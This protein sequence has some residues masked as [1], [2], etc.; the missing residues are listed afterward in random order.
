M[1]LMNLKINIRL[2]RTVIDENININI[3]EDNANC[4]EYLDLSIN[5]I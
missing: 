3:V 2:Q 1:Y 5:I 4:N